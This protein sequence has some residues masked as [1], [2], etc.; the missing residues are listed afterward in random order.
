MTIYRK[1]NKLTIDPTPGSSVSEKQYMRGSRKFFQR[2]SN[3][4][5][6]FY[7]YNRAIIVTLA[8]RHFDGVSLAGRWW[9]ITECYFGNFVVL[10]GNQTGIAKRPYIFVI[11]QGVG[12]GP[13][14]PL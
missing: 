5:Y 13:P 12:S 10:K 7:H 11:F 9:P 1:E 3:F 14:T 4:Y 6:F 8:K 2:G